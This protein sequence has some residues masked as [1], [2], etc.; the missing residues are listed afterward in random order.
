MIR[1]VC[2]PSM[3][4]PEH[5]AF[6]M[7]GNGRWATARHLPRSMGHKEG[8]EA[9]KRVVNACINSGVKYATFFAFS[10]ENWKRPKA[11]VDGLMNLIRN[12]MSADV[13][14]E[15][16]KPVRLKWI[17]STANVPDDVV[18]K[19]R[20]GERRTA[21]NTDFTLVFAFNYG[22]RDEIVRACTV[23]ADNGTEITE[24]S[25]SGALDTSGIPDPDVI[26][27]TAGEKR[28]SNFLIYQGAYSELIFSDTLWPD[29][30]G[31][32]IKKIIEEYNRRTRKFGGINA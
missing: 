27:R 32:E 5:I 25:L 1:V 3:N 23:L 20:D 13:N 2:D 19:I 11:E 16:D 26:V 15:F 17:G 12:F 14:R 7:D 4:I 9:M 31:D 10:T 22:S 28:L 21:D 6:I 18:S 30:D 29:M 24:Q 8:A